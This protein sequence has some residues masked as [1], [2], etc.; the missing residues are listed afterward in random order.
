[1]DIGRLSMLRRMRRLSGG[2]V[3]GP[4]P[5]SS[6][7]VEPAMR[8]R[9]QAK[10]IAIASGGFLRE[11]KT[12]NSLM[13]KSGAGGRED[14]PYPFT[15]M[16]DDESECASLSESKDLRGGSDSEGSAKSAS[17]PKPPD[18]V[19]ATTVFPLFAFLSNSSPVSFSALRLSF[20]AK[21]LYSI[22]SSS[23]MERAQRR[24]LARSKVDRSSPWPSRWSCPSSATP[25]WSRSSR[26]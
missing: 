10:T 17:K 14:D 13:F 19:A 21:R 18:A 4:P 16:I 25:R 23:K 7:G 1:M 8:I 24:A 22:F 15:L 12:F 11:A 2:T 6:G 20:S 26:R 5:P 9:T 3:D